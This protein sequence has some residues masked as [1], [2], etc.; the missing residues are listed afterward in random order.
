MSPVLTGAIHSERLTSRGKRF[1]CPEDPDYNFGLSS[2]PTT[3]AGQGDNRL[4][5]H[6]PHIL[7]SQL[8]S[9]GIYI[10]IFTYANDQWILR[11]EMA[12]DEMAE[13]PLGNI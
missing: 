1:Q 2:L 12:G 11:F 10:Y 6:F 13:L 4:P 3:S 7:S 9:I 5:I 8:K